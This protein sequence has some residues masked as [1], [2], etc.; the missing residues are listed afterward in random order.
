[1]VQDKYAPVL[2]E[3]PYTEEEAEKYQKQ[4][5]KKWRRAADDFQRVVSKWYDFQMDKYQLPHSVFD[6]LTVR[7][8]VMFTIFHNKLHIESILERINS[9]AIPTESESDE[10]LDLL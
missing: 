3:V 4:D 8:M 6:K 7:E 5:L 2:Y 10:Q 1:M 9:K